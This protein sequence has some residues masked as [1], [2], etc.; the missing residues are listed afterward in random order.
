MHAYKQTSNDIY[1]ANIVCS[2]YIIK[3]G[4]NACIQVS[5]RGTNPH[6]ERRKFGA[7][8]GRQGAFDTP[9]LR[10]MAVVSASR[11]CVGW[12]MGMDVRG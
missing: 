8:E 4:L 6:I 2:I 9:T 5:L 3:S 10:V 7:R 12:E 11:E 1:V